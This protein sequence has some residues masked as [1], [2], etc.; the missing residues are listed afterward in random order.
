MA[1]SASFSCRL[2]WETNSHNS[3]ACYTCSKKFRSG[4]RKRHL[5]LDVTVCAACHRSHAHFLSSTSDLEDG[6]VMHVDIHN[7]HVVSDVATQ[8]DFDFFGQGTSSLATTTPPSIIEQES[9]ATAFDIDTIRLPFF[10]ISK[11]SARCFVC[12]KYFVDSSY[13]STKICDSIRATAFINHHIFIPEN[14]HCCSNHIDATDLKSSAYDSI[15]KC[16]DKTCL[17]KINDLMEMLEKLKV[18]LK[19]HIS[20]QEETFARPPI[21]FDNPS[22]LTI[23]DYQILTGLSL[24]QFD[25]LCG[26]IPNSSLYNTNN[27]STRMAIGAL[28]MKLRL[29]L[30]HETLAVLLGFSDRIT[31]HNILQSARA[32]LMKHLIPKYLGF[33][34]I[35]RRTLIEQ[36]T[37]PL[38]KIL[39]ADNNDD[40]AILVLDSTYVY[41]QIP[42][43]ASFSLGYKTYMPKF[44]NKKQNQ[45]STS[46]ANE[47]RL[48]TKV[49]WIVESTNGRIKQ[50]RIFDKVMYNTLIPS[51]GDF[52]SIVCA[53]INRFTSTFISDTSKDQVIAEKMLQLLQQSNELKQ[54]ID[55]LKDD[56]DRNI[57]WYNLD[58]ARAL[59]DFPIFSYQNLMDLTL[60]I[61]QLKQS[62]SYVIEHLNPNGE[63]Y[64]KISNQERDLLRAR[65]QSRHKNIELHIPSKNLA[66]AL[67]LSMTS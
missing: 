48:T 37:R 14:S 54:Y 6:S 57:K 7:D 43:L 17:I 59:N 49:R 39:L 67:P 25:D 53:I 36:R 24:E 44:L 2:F 61:Y 33:E 32:A 1:T 12:P 3:D 8:T 29:A 41:R 50:W 21:D 62:K 42:Q 22:R 58:A 34:H 60:G 4:E 66:G 26:S 10:R 65:I 47:N 27:R 64:V 5:E 16:Y 40:K 9:V 45:F 23:Y 56:S 19:K 35:S 31:V 18:E 51:I 38:A 55:S 13:A 46:E 28:L 15:R 11:S 52:F 20:I 30:T 63:Y